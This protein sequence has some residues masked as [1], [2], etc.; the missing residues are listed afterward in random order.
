MKELPFEFE[1]TSSFCYRFARYHLLQEIAQEPEALSGEPFRMNEVSRRVIECY[2]T[3]EQLAM[4]YPAKEAE[5]EFRAVDAALRFFVSLRAKRGAESPFVWL[6]KGG[7]YRLKTDTELTQEVVEAEDEAAEEVDIEFDGWI[8]AFSFPHIQKGGEAFPIKVGLTTGDVEARVYNQC[9]GSG[10][11]ERPVILGRWQVKRVAQ[12]ED[13]IH[14]VLKARGC[15]MEEAP[16]DEW[17]QTTV[18][19]IESIINFI[20]KSA[21]I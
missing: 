10:F 20:N 14:A 18:V 21:Q 15:W 17:F 12:V 11:F 19:E 3:P 4:T 8:Y 6:G 2:L 1:P 5:G 9:K 13:A 16:G 7:M